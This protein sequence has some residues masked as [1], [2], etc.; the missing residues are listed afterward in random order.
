MIKPTHRKFYKNAPR[1]TNGKQF[2]VTVI[3]ATVFKK[4]K[5]KLS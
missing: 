1:Q 5:I 3:I 2:I 4:I